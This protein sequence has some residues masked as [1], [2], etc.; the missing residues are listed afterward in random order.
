M[1][2]RLS[3]WAINCFRQLGW[4]IIKV[5]DESRIPHVV[6]THRACG[7]Q[8]VVVLGRYFPAWKK[9]AY[10]CL[11]CSC[12]TDEVD[13]HLVEPGT[14]HIPDDGSVVAYALR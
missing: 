1:F 12:V 9:P 14:D 5:T 11:G 10:E 7:S 3:S 6:F 4:Q 8:S 2:W 13:C